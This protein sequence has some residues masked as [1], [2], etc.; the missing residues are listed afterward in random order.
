MGLLVAIVVEA[1][2]GG[3]LPAAL[4]TGRFLGLLAFCVA[5]FTLSG[6]LAARANWSIHE[7]RFGGS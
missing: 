7:R 6:S 3:D 5:V 4:F 2:R 1:A